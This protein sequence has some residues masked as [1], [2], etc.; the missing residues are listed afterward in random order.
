[1]RVRE[2]IAMT[3]VSLA[4]TALVA[5]QQ[6][7]TSGQQ[8]QSQPQDEKM[9]MMDNMSMGDMMKE[10]RKHCEATTNSIDQMTKMMEEAKQSNDPTK[11][12]SALDSAQ[13]PFTEVKDHM[14]MCMH[15]MDMMQ[16]MHG[17]AGPAKKGTK[18]GS[19]KSGKP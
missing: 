19:K 4:L 9:K 6:P 18:P 3:I 10:C 12:R 5:A 14:T 2:L 8:K 16:Q 15:M 1:M 13:K 11:M 17:G 7:A